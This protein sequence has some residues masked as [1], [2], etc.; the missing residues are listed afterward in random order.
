VVSVR[1]DVFKLHAEEL[2]VGNVLK[3][4]TELAPGDG[5]VPIIGGAERAPENVR[6][7]ERGEAQGDGAADLAEN[8]GKSGK[9]R[10][11]LRLK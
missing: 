6:A 5:A 1:V 4:E 3:Q 7:G 8:S 10:G 9:P 2:E 11:N